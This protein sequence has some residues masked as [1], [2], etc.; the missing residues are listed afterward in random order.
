MSIVSAFAKL[1]MNANEEIMKSVAKRR[2]LTVYKLISPK[3]KTNV[4]PLF[5]F[6]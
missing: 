6:I 1:I 2:A 4:S 5:E 3:L